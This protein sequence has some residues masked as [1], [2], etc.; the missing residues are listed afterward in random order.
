V[1]DALTSP[2]CCSTPE[3]VVGFTEC[4][5]DDHPSIDRCSTLE[6]VVG[7]TAPL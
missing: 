5:D 7:F 4:P 2:A 6:G 1:A 3:G